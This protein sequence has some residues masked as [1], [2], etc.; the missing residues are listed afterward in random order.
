MFATKE[1]AIPLAWCV[2]IHV[3]TKLDRSSSQGLRAGV[4]REEAQTSIG[5]NSN[6]SFQILATHAST[7]VRGLGWERFDVSCLKHWR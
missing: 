5:A 2:S 7:R 4:S 6:K 3:L 1:P